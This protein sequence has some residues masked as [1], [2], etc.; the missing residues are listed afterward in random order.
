M[1]NRLIQISDII[2]G[3]RTRKFMGDIASLAQNIAEIGLLHPVVID[4]FDNLIAGERRIRAYQL[5]GWTKIPVTIVDLAEIVRGEFAE[6][7]QR[8]DFVP[9]EIDAIRVAMAPFEAAAAKERQGERTDLRET[10]PEVGTPKKENRARDKIA[11]FA[12]VSGRSIEKIAAIVAA[13]KAEPEN[14]RLAKLVGDMDRTGKVNGPYKRLKVLRQ[15]AAIRAEPPSLPM[16][17]PYRVIVADPPWPYD[18]RQ[19]DPTHRATHPYPQMSIANI[20]A[21]PVRALAHDDCILWLWTTNFHIREAFTVLD[22]WDFTHRTILTWAKDS[23]GMGDWL[24]GRTE[25]CIMAVRGK[26]IVQLTTETTLLHGQM[27][28]HSQKPEEFYA[29]VEK[30]CPAPLYAE[31]FSRQLR[32]GW[33]GHG[34]EHKS[35]APDDL[36]IPSYLRRSKE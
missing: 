11:A 29:F 28:A 8:K 16:R 27:R 22:A 25:H 12:G 7:S 1:E 34:D 30:L 9:T 36:E 15:S 23:M 13:A 35:P 20:C 18:V 33:D 10:C 3:E 17:G 14:E 32:A 31:L 5:L 26:P 6:N 4:K 19:E 2:I 24:R 21:L